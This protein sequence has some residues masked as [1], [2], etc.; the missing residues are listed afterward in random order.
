MGILAVVLGGCAVGRVAGA[1]GVEV[2]RAALA[3][4]N[5]VLALQAGQRVLARDPSDGAALVVTG[6]ALA[7]LGQVGHAVDRLRAGVARVPSDWGAR[8]VLG[9]L[10][11]RISPGVAAVQFRAVVAARP[12]DWVAWN[13]LGVVRDLRGRHRAARVAYRTALAAR[14]GFRAAQVNLA[15]SLAM[16]GR[17]A[18]AAE[19][20][21]TL[22]PGSSGRV[23]ADWAA[24]TAMAG[25]PRAAAGMLGAAMPADQV[26]AAIQAYTALGSGG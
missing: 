17:A 22:G 20:M 24:V 19:M 9:R 8:V 2:A 5:P 11:A 25:H 14:P 4:G 13:D 1:P 21:R 7:A 23:R 18:E 12:G 26:A 15:L 3:G 10:L 6:E 16:S